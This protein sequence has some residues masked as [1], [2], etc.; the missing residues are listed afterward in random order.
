MRMSK[1]IAITILAVLLSAGRGFTQTPAIISG[2]DFNNFINSDL[3]YMREQDAFYA[4]VD[5]SPYLDEEFKSG[6]L[7]YNNKLYANLS[8]RYNYYE[9]YFEFKAGDEVKY[10]DPRYLEVDT[11][12]LENDKF[13]YVEFDNGRNVRRNYMKLLHDGPVKVLSYREIVL[14]EA[15]KAKG[16]E[17]ARPARFDPRPEVIYIQFG[18]APAVEFKNKRSIGEVF[19]DRTE[20][21][22]KYAKSEKLK[23]RDPDD[24]VTL[25]K[26]YETL[27]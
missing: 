20:V 13:I 25:V 5:G 16:Y 4:R 21:L 3:R 17:D 12:W 18:D 27:D 23:F 22:E 10:Y 6:A 8:L 24:L 11:V 26:Y 14:L 19:P 7:V 1:R 15:Q 9:G 2:S